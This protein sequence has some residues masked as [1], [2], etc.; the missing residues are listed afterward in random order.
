MAYD[1]ADRDA[2][3][4]AQIGAQADRHIVNLGEIG[5]VCQ[6]VLLHLE[7]D[8]AVIIGALAPAAA[9]PGLVVPGQGLIT[10]HHAVFI[11][12]DHS[13]DALGAGRLVPV[14]A[15][16]IRADNPIVRA[17]IPAEVWI[18]GAS[19]VHDDPL[20][21]HPLAGLIAPVVCQVI[22]GNLHGLSS[23]CCRGIKIPPPG[24]QT[25][26]FTAPIK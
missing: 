7:L 13:V 6:I 10:A 8:M 5:G 15:V 9:A 1:C 18:V 16:L 24:G 11:L 17:D 3:C 25:S 23:P 4:F 20:G 12:A 26:L 14:I 21:R 19:R 22:L 2:I